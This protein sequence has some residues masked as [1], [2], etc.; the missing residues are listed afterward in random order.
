[1]TQLTPQAA[2]AQNRR[3]VQALLKSVF[4]AGPSIAK[5]WSASG[6]ATEGIQGYNIETPLLSLYP[7]LTPLL[8]MTPRIVSGKGGSQANWKAIT[9]IKSGVGHRI[10]VGEGHRSASENHTTAEY[11]A[12]YR[13]LGVDDDMS[14][15][16]RYRAM[17]FA[18]AMSL[19]SLKLMER[20]KV[21]QELLIFGGNT[22]LQLGTTPT[23]VLVSKANA[24]QLP[25]GDYSVICVALGLDALSDVAGTNNGSVG[26]TF[27]SANS[28]VPGQITRTNKD[29]SNDTFGGG[30]A[31]PSVA[32]AVAAVGAGKA[33]D[34][35]IPAAVRG[36][37][38]YA[39]FLGAA[40][41]EKLV[42]VSRTTS[43]TLSVTADVNAQ[44]ASTLVGDNSTNSLIYDGLLTM[45]SKPGYGG[46][47]MDMGGAALTGAA[48]GI[49][50]ISDA[51]QA[52]WDL[53]RLTPDV[54]ICS[55]ADS[56]RINDL[57]LGQP[58]PQ[59]MLTRS[60]NDTSTGITAGGRVERLVNH[61][62]NQPVELLSHPNC[63]SGTLLM[64]STSAPAYAN[65]L[66]NLFEVEA[67]QDTKVEIWPR[68][69][70]QEE[71]GVYSQEV[72]KHRMPASLTAIT[73]FA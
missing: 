52:Q 4:E 29:G 38:G 66:T 14:D 57:V 73:N 62:N 41:A 32:L 13:S 39:W 6:V 34:V 43:V 2:Y 5:S 49:L 1:M 48:G 16:A 27:T 56:R 53:Y 30:S 54:I 72:F 18:D 51:L 11:F 22:S 44:L 36:A 23:P 64:M 9:G 61:V 12:A 15:E 19:M 20:F 8:N 68:R 69:T 47:W 70:R 7:L 42:A 63:P 55:A 24:G 17:G 33:I 45:A 71:I 40:G 31:A 10:G 58:N 59:V 37:F 65:G 50:E 60:I 46:N 26:Q 3:D 21:G 67:I 25:A 35:K 28:R